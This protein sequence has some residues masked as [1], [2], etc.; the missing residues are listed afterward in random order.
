MDKTLEALVASVRGMV[1]SKPAH[2]CP[3]NRRFAG[4]FGDL[5]RQIATITTTP[6][7]QA[8]EG[9][10]A[11]DEAGAEAACYQA[12]QAVGVM[13]S[14]LGL[15]DTERGQNLLD[16]LSQ[17][18]VVHEVLPWESASPPPSAAEGIVAVHKDF[19]FD[20]VNQ[21]HIPI[22]TIAFQGVPSNVGTYEKGW[23][24]RDDLAALL[25]ARPSGG[26][27]VGK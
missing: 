19:L 24:D 7:R 18:R 27:E 21:Q 13:L 25:A 15:F 23:K 4:H 16:N 10:K 17:A 3:P 1:D 12:Y 11:V 26:G 20:E 8:A 9:G 6:A 5:E 22:L 2:W 14:D